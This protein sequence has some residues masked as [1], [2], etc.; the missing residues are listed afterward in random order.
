MATM[1]TLFMGPLCN[2]MGGWEK[3]LTGIHITGHPIH[4]II[5]NPPLLRSLF[6][7]FSLEHKYLHIFCPFGEFY[8]ID[9]PQVSVLQIFQSRSIQVPDDSAKPLATA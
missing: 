8:P 3:R 7:I 9:L 2:D 5:K 1:A 4:L 6:V